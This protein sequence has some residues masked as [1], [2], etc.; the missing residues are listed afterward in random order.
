[1]VARHFLCCLPLRLG[2]LLISLVQLVLGGLIAVG[3]WYSLTSL[4]TSYACSFLFRLRP[5]PNFL[6]SVGGRLPSKL[7]GIIIASAVYYSA[8]ALTSLIGLIG[9]LG[10]KASLLS[11]YAFYL[12]WSVGVQ[13]VIDAVY[14]WGFLSTS[15]E[16]IIQRCIDGSTDKDVQNICNSSF[17]TGKWTTVAGI[18]LGL[19]IQICESPFSRGSS[20]LMIAPIR[21]CLHRC[22]VC[23]KVVKGEVVEIWPRCRFCERRRRWHR[24]RPCKTG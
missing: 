22:L 9:A 8:L 21:G 24:L 12:S 11:T 13:I 7:K 1:M 10:R 20:S 17:D 19:V 5:T 2:A 3:A 14:L 4:R 6:Q 18:A 15:R 23:G 16:T